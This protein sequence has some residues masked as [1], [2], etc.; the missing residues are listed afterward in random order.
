MGSGVWRLMHTTI[1]YFINSVIIAYASS[2][3]AAIGAA[4]GMNA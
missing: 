3:F 1:S 2:D 4:R